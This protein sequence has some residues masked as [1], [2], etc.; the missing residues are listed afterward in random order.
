MEGGGV[1]SSSAEAAAGRPSD[2]G[3]PVREV[4][5][6]GLQRPVDVVAGGTGSSCMFGE[7]C[8]ESG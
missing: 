8:R 3:I 6:L 5:P 2:L 7:S 4:R 1:V